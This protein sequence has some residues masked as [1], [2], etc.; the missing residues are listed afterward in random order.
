MA[1]SKKVVDLVLIQIISAIMKARRGDEGA[2]P[3]KTQP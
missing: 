3:A 1:L 2:S